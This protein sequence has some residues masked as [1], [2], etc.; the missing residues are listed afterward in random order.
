MPGGAASH[1]VDALKSAFAQAEA[2]K[3]VPTVLIAKCVKGK[4][5]SF[6]ENRC[7]WHGKAP[8]KE[9]LAAALAE[10]EGGSPQ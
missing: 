1:D 9:E 6:M 3:G 4:G 8:D 5:V 10:V 2:V 7:A